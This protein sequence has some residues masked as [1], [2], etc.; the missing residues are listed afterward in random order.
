MFIFFSH[1]YPVIPVLCFEEISL[2]EL[3]WHSVE[4]QPA[5]SIRGS[6]SGLS[7]VP[8]ICIYFCM[9]PETPLNPLIS[10]NG[11]FVNYWGFSMYTVMSSTSRNHFIFSFQIFRPLRLLFSCLISIARASHHTVLNRTSEAWS[12]SSKVCSSFPKW[13]LYVPPLQRWRIFL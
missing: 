11:S 4:S 13:V 8:L 10:S 5:T 6:T 7:S 2:L 3:L 12:I 1:E 9:Y